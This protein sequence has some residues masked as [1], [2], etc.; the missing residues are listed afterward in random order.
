MKKDSSKI[1]YAISIVVLVFLTFVIAKQMR[2][3]KNKIVSFRLSINE[4]K[5]KLNYDEKYIGTQIKIDSGFRDYRSDSRYDSKKFKR[6]FSIYLVL[7]KINCQPCIGDFIKYL[8]EIPQK[9]VDCAIVVC[10]DDRA[11]LQTITYESNHTFP[12]FYTDKLDWFEKYDV[13][14]GPAIFIVERDTQKIVAFYKK[15]EYDRWGF[16]ER[17]KNTILKF[18]EDK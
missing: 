7:G 8:T 10:S 1:F 3:D 15:T 12:V 17:I 2:N 9:N 11:M 6:N 14:S 4:M 5:K 18:A 13:V 16:E